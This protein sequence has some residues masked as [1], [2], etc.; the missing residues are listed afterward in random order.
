[1]HTSL[2]IGFYALENIWLLPEH[3]VGTVLYHLCY[4]EQEV[5]MQAIYN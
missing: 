1:M 3:P 4:I 2:E 5:Q